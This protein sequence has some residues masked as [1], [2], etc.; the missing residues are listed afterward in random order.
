[1]SNICLTSKDLPEIKD[2]KVGGTYQLVLEVQ[3][4]S[5]NLEDQMSVMETPVEEVTREK[6]I[7]ADFKIVKIKSASK[8]KYDT[9]LA[10]Y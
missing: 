10:D 9:S 6:G 7:H 3:Q 4:V 8:K 5:A 2:W 1:M